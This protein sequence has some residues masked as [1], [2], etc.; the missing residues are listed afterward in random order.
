M[1]EL[2]PQVGPRGV[3]AVLPHRSYAAVCACADG[4]GVRHDA[5]WWTAEQQRLVSEAYARG[6]REAV[7]ALGLQ[8]TIGAARQMAL[9]PSARC[10]SASEIKTLRQSWQS[11]GAAA[12]Y[13]ALPHRSP[14]GVKAKA[15]ELKLRQPHTKTTWDRVDLDMLRAMYPTRGPIG[16]AEAMTWR[17]RRAIYAKAAELGLQHPRTTVTA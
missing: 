8:R 5:H 9:L 17:T 2:Y 4:L 15:R 14:S 6:G 1:R 16:C 12:A 13:A 11:R 7:R 3:V 10:W